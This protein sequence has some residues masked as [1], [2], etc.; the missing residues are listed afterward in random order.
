[1]ATTD[2]K[3]YVALGVLAVLGGA[4]FVADKKQKEEAQ[5]YTPSGRSAELPKIDIKDEDIKAINRIVLSK[6]ADDKDAAGKEGGGPVEV[7]LVKVGEEWQLEKPVKAPANQA[8]VKSMLDNLKSLKASE[9][10]DPG[11][12]AY[13]KYGLA[14]G[15]GLHAVFSKEGGTVF[16]AWFGESGGRGQMT[17]IAGKDGVYSVKGYSSYLYARDVKGWRDMT[18][19]KFEDADVTAVSVTNEHGNFEFT[20]AG[21]KWAAK[22]RKP[23]GGLAPLAKFSEEKL[24]DMLRA[25]RSLNADNFAEPGK[26]AADLGLDKPVATAVLTLKDGAKKQVELGSTSEGSSRWARVSGKDEFFSVS[27]WAADWVLAEPKKFEPSDKPAGGDPGANPH[28]LPEGMQGMQ[29]MPPGMGED[30]H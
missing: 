19:F 29:G 23:Q 10:I 1:M 6:G 2:T 17:R 27:S 26:S 8:N 7:T 21:D 4:Y 25:F 13:D 11:K 5:H 16:E 24:K 12:T 20:K 14:E 9:L 15:K 18:L 30:P 28:G 3:L 22:H